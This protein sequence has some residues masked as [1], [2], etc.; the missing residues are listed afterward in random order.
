ME[1][2]PPGTVPAPWPDPGRIPAPW[3]DW[4]QRGLSFHKAGAGVSREEPPERRREA[5][6]ADLAT[7]DLAG[8]PD[9]TVYSDGSAEDGTRNGAGG[10][11]ISWHDGRPRTLDSEP[12]GA[13]TCSTTAE[14]VAAA[15]GLEI[16]DHVTRLEREPAHLK[17]RICFDSLSLF[18]RLQ[19]FWTTI[20]EPA[21]LR[22][23]TAAASIIRSGHTIQLCWIPGHAGIAGN[24]E[25]D[26]VAGAGRGGDQAGVPLTPG[27]LKSYLKARSKR[28]STEHYL[29]STDP[30]STHRVATNGQPPPTDTWPREDAVILHRLRVNRL[31]S[32][33]E[34]KHRWGRV[35]SPVCPHCGLAPENSQHFITD[36]PFF[37]PERTRWLG[38]TPSL[39]CLQESP[40]QVLQFVRGCARRI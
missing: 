10:V 29:Q 28:R 34:T 40:T 16:V 32:L 38:P 8:A 39:A 30:T 6:E 18:Q 36:C 31:A 13:I 17:I 2:L 35:D 33:Q 1:D 26:A 23:V 12:A 11:V 4:S 37:N 19:G 15:L 24:E 7:L 20:N 5:A 22:L 3:E 25:A 27:A 9:I 21:L 14:T